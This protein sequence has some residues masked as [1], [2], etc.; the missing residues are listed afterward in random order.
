MGAA[1]TARRRRRQHAIGFRHLALICGK[2]VQG[3]RP[4][5]RRRA[6]LSVAEAIQRERAFA[7]KHAK[8][9]M[10]RKS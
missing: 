5:Y 7:A 2:A 3:G 4:L 9:K 1:R 6:L 10:K 8:M